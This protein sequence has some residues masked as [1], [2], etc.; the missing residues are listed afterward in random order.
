MRRRWCSGVAR[1]ARDDGGERSGGN[2]RWWRRRQVDGDGD[3]EVALH[4]APGG[5]AAAAPVHVQR[6]AHAEVEAQGRVAVVQ[7]PQLPLSLQNKQ[8]HLDQQSQLLECW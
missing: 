2:A 5:G 6:P 4:P 7:P 8:A 3:L 1:S